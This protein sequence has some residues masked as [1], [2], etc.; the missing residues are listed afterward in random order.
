[1]KKLSEIEITVPATKSLLLGGREEDED[2]GG[3][4]Y[5]RPF[6]ILFG[7]LTTLLDN[8]IKIPFIFSFFKLASSTMFLF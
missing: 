7:S 6:T 2:E 1:M 8:S 5:S 4:Q 3:E